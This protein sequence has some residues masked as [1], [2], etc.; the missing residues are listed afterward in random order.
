MLLPPADLSGLSDDD[1]KK[2][3]DVRKSVVSYAL[4]KVIW[5]VSNYTNIPID[6]LPSALDYTVVDMTVQVIQTH[7]YLALS[8][9]EDAG[10]DVQSL[11]EGDTSITFKSKADVYASLQQI[12]TI[13][14]NYT[15]ILNN[16]RVVV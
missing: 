8:K 13:S 11:S 10:S 1:A 6:E 16:F 12:N 3:Q 4:S 2:Y 14:D 15:N 9:G 5:D 7:D